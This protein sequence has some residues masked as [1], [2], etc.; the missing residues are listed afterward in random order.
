MTKT[1]PSPLAALRRRSLL[2]LAGAGAMGL[3]WP[4]A[5]AAAPAAGNGKL[6]ILSMAGHDIELVEHVQQIGSRMPPK[7]QRLP[8]GTGLL[9]Q[10]ATLA[11]DKQARAFLPASDIVLLSAQGKM[12]SELQ[13]D[14]IDSA[15][16]MKDMIATVADA[17][18]QAG[19]SHALALMKQRGVAKLRLADTA[20]GLGMLEGLGFY[21]DTESET[22][23]KGTQESHKGVLAPYAYVRLLYVDAKGVRLLGSEIA[24]DST[25]VTLPAGTLGHPWDALTPDAKATALSTLVEGAVSR[26]VPALMAPAKAG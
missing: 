11:L 2:S 19:C 21:I 18:Q 20:I 10:R 13:R 24:Q 12:W 26:L 7:R 1:L 9:D 22:I 16:G 3:A 25:S 17:A 8:L 23:T 15:A 5:R 6:A 14:A 4:G